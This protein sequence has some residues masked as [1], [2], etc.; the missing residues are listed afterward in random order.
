MM[1][2]KTGS[3]IQ[4]KQSSETPNLDAGKRL[5]VRTVVLLGHPGERLAGLDT[6]PDSDV[7]SRRR[8][9]Q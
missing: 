6:A 3:S 7:R 2:C 9:L 5:R 1:C 4:G 8:F